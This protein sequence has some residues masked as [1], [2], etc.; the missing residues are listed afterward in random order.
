MFLP[1]WGSIRHEWILLG[2]NWE[3]KSMVV[4]TKKK[5]GIFQSLHWRFDDPRDWICIPG[6]R[7]G[8]DRFPPR[9]EVTEALPTSLRSIKKATNVDMSELSSY[10]LFRWWT[11]IVRC[12][13]RKFQGRIREN[14][15]SCGTFL[16]GYWM[17][18]RTCA[19]MYMLHLHIGLR[20]IRDNYFILFLDAW[21]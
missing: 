3:K 8:R 16:P 14:E 12:Q 11:T 1:Y 9:T 21:A 7:T 6:I 19:C 18:P 10:P 20:Q 4:F 15:Q 17:L 13:V 5:R 2:C